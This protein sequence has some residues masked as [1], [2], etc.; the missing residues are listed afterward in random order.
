MDLYNLFRKKLHHRC[1]VGFEILLWNRINPFS[2]H[3]SLKVI[4]SNLIGSSIHQFALDII[5]SHFT[6]RKKLSFPLRIPSVNPTKSA[7]STDLVTFTEEI[8]NGKIHF[9]CR[10]ECKKQYTNIFLLPRLHTLRK[11]RPYSELFCSAF[12]RIRNKYGE[13]RSISPYL[14]QMR[15]NEDQNN[16]EYEE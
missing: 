1:L 13:M 8:L 15:E 16:S 5:L 10:K 6:L 2:G 7:V 3:N 9:L 4:S 14:V 12:S 11:K